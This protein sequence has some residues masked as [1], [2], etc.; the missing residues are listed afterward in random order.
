M[1]PGPLEPA[2]ADTRALRLTAGRGHLV[3]GGL[4]EEHAALV[5]RDWSR[6]DPRPAAPE[7]KAD[8]S[9]SGGDAQAWERFHEELVYRITARTIDSARGSHLMFHGAVLADQRTGAGIVLA[10][11]SGTGKT[12]ATRRLG[13]HYAYLTDETAILDPEDLSVTPYP[14]PLSL[15]GPDGAR[16]KHQAG[17]EELGLGPTR[18]AQIRAVAVLDR[19]RD[20]QGQVPARA[21]RMSLVDALAVL[22]PQTSSL[23][24]LPR[25]LVA[26]CRTL[27]RLG[28]A[29]RL[30]YAESE[31]LRPVVDGLLAEEPQPV[32]PAWEPLAEYELTASLEDPEAPEAPT[33]S[34]PVLRRSG[35]DCGIE[36]PDGR[37]VL[38]AHEQLVI[39]DGLGPALWSLLDTPRSVDG[40]L[41]ELE[42]WA[43]LPEGARASVEAALDALAGERLVTTEDAAPGS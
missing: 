21:E 30:V 3:V 15:L 26:L 18:P 29:R 17:P 1:G 22:V 35:A 2:Q 25:G 34:G 11:A 28:G 10:A 37:L 33:A 27:D 24:R 41:A 14:K 8:L 31:D 9:W 23:A 4:D 20:P 7:D 43:P 6:C 36:L 32:E 38:L 39:L 16:P 42:A 12:T 13:P 40:L 19:V 5:A